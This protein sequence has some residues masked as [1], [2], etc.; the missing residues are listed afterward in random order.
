MGNFFKF[1]GIIVL[2]AM[3][4]FS[5]AACDDGSGNNAGGVN[6]GETWLISSTNSFSVSNGIVGSVISTKNITWLSYTDEKNF[7][8]R[9]DNIDASNNQ[10]YS[11]SF[12]QTGNIYQSTSGGNT[13]TVVYDE[14]SGI[15][16][17]MASNGVTIYNATIELTE[18]AGN[19]RTFSVIYHGVTDGVIAVYKIRN[20]G[21]VLEVRNHNTGDNSLVSTTTFSFP[22]D[23][24]IRTRLPT[25]TL[26]NTVQETGVGSF[27]QTCE[28]LS[29]SDT[30]MVIRG[31]I[32]SDGAFTGQY[33]NTYIRWN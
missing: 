17:S 14:A 12:S 10:Q 11:I 33:D 6:S 2:V 7:S 26:S 20:D 32:F 13:T 16:Q 27:Y 30:E 22:Q 23:A 21:V 19:V 29:Y 1:F 25:F 31:K 8:G 5:M 24:I 9:E 18:T 28:V 15:M 4:G 3:I